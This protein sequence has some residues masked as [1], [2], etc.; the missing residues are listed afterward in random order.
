MLDSLWSGPWIIPPRNGRPGLH[1][2]AKEAPSR[3]EATGVDWLSHP[4][5]KDLLDL[6][7]AKWFA[8]IPGDI[9]P[10]LTVGDVGGAL[11]EPGEGAELAAIA[12]GVAGAG[13]QGWDMVTRAGR[14]REDVT[15]LGR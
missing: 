6:S 9:L 14:P 15:L 5:E 12:G 8:S 1:P 11:V 3:L 13:K 2:L 4:E 7:W 10:S